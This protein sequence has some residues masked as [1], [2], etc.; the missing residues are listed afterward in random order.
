MIKNK[1]FLAMVTI[2]SCFL[3]QNICTNQQNAQVS[4]NNRNLVSEEEIEKA[5]GFLGSFDE[6]IARSAKLEA[7]LKKMAQ[8]ITNLRKAKE[9]CATK[10]EM[11]KSEK[12]RHA[13]DQLN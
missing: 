6:V 1:M 12:L 7:L 4:K 9:S 11:Q 13:I 5:I 3:V 10:T 2:I 8:C